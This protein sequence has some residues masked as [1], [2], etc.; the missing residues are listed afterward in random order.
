MRLP[1]KFYALL[2]K[3]VTSTKRLCSTYL[4]VKIPEFIFNFSIV[5]DK[6][7]FYLDKRG[8]TLN[9]QIQ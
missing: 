7:S 9:K 2:Q 6:Q 1:P 5:K 8:P 4:K 3:A